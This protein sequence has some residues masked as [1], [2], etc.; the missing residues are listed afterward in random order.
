MNQLP[1]CRLLYVLLNIIV[2]FFSLY[3]ASAVADPVSIPDR[4]KD[5]FNTVPGWLIAPYIFDYPGLGK[6]YGIVG[7][8]T[9]IG[10]TY[11]T[12]GGTVFTGDVIGQAA[13]IYGIHLIPRQLILDAGAIYVSRITLL[14]Y[15]QRGMG[16]QK[17][18]HT[19]LEYGSDAFSGSRLT[20]TFFDRRFEL[21]AGIYGGHAQFK[22]ILD[23]DGNVIIEAQNA[24]KTRTMTIVFGT[25]LDMTDDYLDPRRGFRFEMSRWNT[26]AQD[27]GPDFF[28]MDYSATAYVPFG[29]AST[30]AFNY[31]RSDAYVLSKGE[32]DPSVIAQHLGLD[33]STITNPQQQA[34]CQQVIDNEIAANTYGT[35]SSLGGL[36][37]LRSYPEGRY[38]GAHT[39]FFGTE[40]RWNVTEEY[41]PFNIVIM[42]DVRTAFQIALFYEIGTVSDRRSELWDITRSSYGVGFRMVTASGLVYRVDLASGNEGFQTSVFFQ[43]PW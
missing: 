19:L 9:N 17:N 30:W 26:P 38:K 42:K 27:L 10:G 35:A 36:S 33:C 21:F 41:K 22:S 43:Y 4:R 20:A 3:A 16:T 2:L 5:Q 25:R 13:G 18:D 23:R 6:G 39:E 32:T 24:A 28:F 11:T 12:V 29:R 1:S 14:S 7:G 40:I 31:F 8:A 34:Q 37:R 15:S